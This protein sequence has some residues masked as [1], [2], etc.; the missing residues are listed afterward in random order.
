MF[1]WLLSHRRL[2]IFSP[3]RCYRSFISSLSLALWKNVLIMAL[4]STI[5]LEFHAYHIAASEWRNLFQRFSIK[6]FQISVARTKARALPDTSHPQDTI[7]WTVSHGA[8]AW[9]QSW[10]HE[11]VAGHQCPSVSVLLLQRSPGCLPSCRAG[12]DSA[13]YLDNYLTDWNIFWNSVCVIEVLLPSVAILLSHLAKDETRNE[14][15]FR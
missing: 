8:Q 12:T 14:N 7:V 11:T 1:S 6:L 2:A 15:M 4:W 13:A 5:M 10:E 3:E 9:P